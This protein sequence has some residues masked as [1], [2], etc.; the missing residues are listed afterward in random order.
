MRVE[1][2]SAY[3]L[4]QRNYRE[5]SL[6][7]EVFSSLHG[8]IGLVAKGARRPRSALRS[9]LQTFRP[10]RLAWSGRSDLGVLTSAEPDGPFDPLVGRCLASGF[11]LNELLIRTLHRYDSHP[12]LFRFY[13][14]ALRSLPDEDAAEP[15]LRLFEKRLLEELGYG[16]VLAREVESGAAIKGSLTYYY[17]EGHGPCL[18]PPASGPAVKI[19]GDT[20]IALAEERLTDEERLRESKSL[21]R[22]LLKPHIGPRKLYSRELF[23]SGLE[24]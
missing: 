7:L 3:I 1:L 24:T 9:R 14:Q 18:T 11:Y 12:H 20:L 8:R 13:D 22:F 10:L 6:I 2:H 5:T 16:P 23:H 19:Q 21:M 17:R 15:I 4:H